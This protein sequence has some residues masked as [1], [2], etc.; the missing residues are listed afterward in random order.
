MA[1]RKVNFTLGSAK[2][3]RIEK[4]YVST[5]T[6]KAF[7]VLTI[8]AFI[9]LLS[10]FLIKLYQYSAVANNVEINLGNPVYTYSNYLINWGGVLALVCLLFYIRFAST[11]TE[12]KNTV[13]TPVKKVTKKKIVKKK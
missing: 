8:V 10:G 9:A 12:K 4:A 3:A 7:Y 6:G 2:E 1:K 13:K 11:Y 5:G